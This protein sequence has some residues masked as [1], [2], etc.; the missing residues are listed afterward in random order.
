MPDGSGVVASLCKRR[1]ETRRL[2]RPAFAPV[3]KH[4]VTAR[5]ERSAGNEGASSAADAPLQSI[6]GRQ[7]RNTA[8]MESG[9]MVRVGRHDHI[10]RQV[11]AELADI[12]ASP[13]TLR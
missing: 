4:V 9:A 11:P 6:S 3:S 1:Y 13:G 2:W 5:G 10:L 12:G 7:G 8:C